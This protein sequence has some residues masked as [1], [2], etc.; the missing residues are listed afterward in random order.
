MTL[1]MKTRLTLTRYFCVGIEGGPALGTAGIVGLIVVV[2]LV[3]VVAVDA[4]FCKTK[5]CG[6]CLLYTSPSPRDI[7]VSRM[8]SSA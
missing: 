7:L 2:L 3:L 6:V 1:C 8:P 5:Q 4:A